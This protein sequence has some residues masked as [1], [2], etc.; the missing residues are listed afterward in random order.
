[1]KKTLLII[2]LFALLIPAV[3]WATPVSL[4]KVGS[5]ESL[6][7]PLDWLG[8]GTSSPQAKLDVYDN[9]TTG[10]APAIRIGGN[11][12]GDSDAWICRFNDNDGVND[13]T[14]R[15]GNGSS[16]ASTSMFV[17][18]LANGNTA[19]GTSTPASKLQLFSTAT[20]GQ[21]LYITK[22]NSGTNDQSG[23]TIRFENNHAVGIGR[24]TN[25]SGGKMSF[26]YSQPSSGAS[27]EGGR[28][29][30][31]VGAVSQSGGNTPSDLRF[32]TWTNAGSLTEKMRITD[33]GNVGIA[34]AT[35]AYRFVSTSG[36]TSGMFQT[37]GASNDP[38]YVQSTVAGGYSTIGFLNSLNSSIGSLGYAN[39][40]VGG[41]LRDSF[42][43]QT[44]S[45]P[46]IFS[47]NSGTTADLIIASSTGAI[48]IGTSTPSS[49]L[50]IYATAGCA[51]MPF[52]VSSSTNVSLFEIECNG[53]VGVGT[54]TAGYLFTVAG[55]TNQ[56]GA[57]RINGN[58]GTAG[59]VLQSNGTS[60][61]TWVA[62]STLG[63]SGGGSGNSAWTIG[64]GLIYN[65]TSTDFVGIGTTTPN[66]ILHVYG[67][68]SGGIMKIERFN[69][70]TTGFLGTQIIKALSTGDMTDGFGTGQTFAIQ[71]NA[72]VENLIAQVVAERSGADNTGR[73]SFS[74]YYLGTPY[75]ALSLNAN[76][77]SS[78]FGS[79]TANTATLSV[80]GSGVNPT[81]DLFNISSS[82]GNTLFIVRP[83]GN[84]GIGTSTPQ[85]KLAVIGD[86]SNVGNFTFGAN[87]L[88]NVP[89]A[90]GT[91][92]HQGMIATSSN[93]IV[94]TT[95]V[96]TN[97]GSMAGTGLFFGNNATA[98]TGPGLLIQNNGNIVYAGSNYN[99]VANGTPSL[100]AND[101][102]IFTKGG[103]L[104]LASVSATSSIEFFTGQNSFNTIDSDAKLDFL[105]NFGIGFGTTTI[106]ARL[107]VIGATTTG[108][109]FNVA[110]STGSSLFVVKPSGFIGIGTTT[111][112]RGVLI[113]SN[114]NS[115][116]KSALEIAN[117]NSGNLGSAQLLLRNN[118]NN[119]FGMQTFSSGY[120]VPLLRNKAL[121]VTSM[122]SGMSFAS[123]NPTADMNFLTNSADDTSNERMR[124]TFDGN[125]G[126]GTSTPRAKVAIVG[127]ATSSNLFTIASSTGTT[128]M[129]VVNNAGRMG[130]ASSTPGYTLSVNGTVGFNRTN[131]GANTG[132]TNPV[133][134]DVDGRALVSAFQD[135][136]TSDERQKHDIKP[137]T[138]T[139]SGLDL[140]RNMT[141]WTFAM[142]DSG[143]EKIG[144]TAQEMEK[145]DPVL[146]RFGHV[147]ENGGGVEI[148][149]ITAANTQAIKELDEQV[150]GMSGSTNDNTP[151]WPLWYAIFGLVIWNVYQQKKINKLT[152]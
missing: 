23:G 24:S 91:G 82:T 94:G 67:N 151:V 140:V 34:S 49:K 123:E 106:P 10:C 122:A 117:S 152:R 11:N 135:C 18:D 6:F 89:T 47:R 28:I 56:T 79:S 62:T 110:S 98:T 1:M 127:V 51:G 61:P 58:P 46:I 57:L 21:D 40:A 147:D 60:A 124:I 99:G 92:V 142:N 48:G 149:A 30:S 16:T 32:M 66:K 120:I 43:I 15:F 146:K 41:L 20:A 5:F 139:Y 74:P 81:L 59:F 114:D 71:D 44:G 143:K 126:I 7:Y 68:Q 107:S 69:A 137:L 121:F 35:P 22:G 63:I 45:K 138:D 25:V 86:I 3:V 29:E 4:N 80:F 14:L 96:N 2:S 100:S 85:S 148:Y 50:D 132:T 150:Q 93:D 103:G 70:A 65:A 102:A 101:M 128:S 83:N 97:S 64:D 36:G 111:P 95:I 141:T 115:N 109:I 88:Q 84:V 133:C 145:L 52:R 119:Y 37:T 54:T 75:S 39:T 125:I 17:I 76:T 31:L 27:Q 42:F 26:F 130:L 108:D 33:A 12:G 144:F 72:G 90:F 19:L 9:D 112:A 104:K 113:A 77:Q 55:D 53:N 129:I 78:A 116:I 118:S 73:L 87:I 105:G 8:L 13:D 136:T 131:L 134:L 38:L